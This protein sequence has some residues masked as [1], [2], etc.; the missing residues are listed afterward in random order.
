MC[1]NCEWLPPVRGGRCNACATFWYRN[2]RERPEALVVK[3]SLH[4]EGLE[5]M[6]EM[7]REIKRR[8]EG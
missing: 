3:H 5:S 8:T 7:Y 6:R 2:K 4:L 1:S